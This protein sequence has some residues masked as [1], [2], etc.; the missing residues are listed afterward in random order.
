[1]NL[2]AKLPSIGCLAIL[3]TNLALAAFL[4]WGFQKPP[5]HRV[6][7]LHHELKIGAVGKLSPQDHALLSTELH[8]HA[9]LA[10]ALLSEGSIG[11]VSA[12]SD[13]WLETPDATVIRSAK[14]GA[15]CIMNLHVKIPDDALPLA[16]EVSGSGWQ[17]SL[18]IG[19]QGV[20]RLPLPNTEAAPE[21]ITL[22][23]VAK[24]SDAEVAT[25]GVRVTFDCV[26]AKGARG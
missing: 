26:S 24:G 9:E 8:E 21:I 23:V 18:S 11:L 20:T 15:P 5:L 13:G 14:A 2:T 17:R 19:R 4:I 25:M 6:W 16:V 1:M 7:E 12:N 3:L 10:G 22:A